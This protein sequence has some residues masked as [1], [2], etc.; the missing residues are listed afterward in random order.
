MSGVEIV[1]SSAHLSTS[2][3]ALYSIIKILSVDG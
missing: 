3:E 1:T 2:E